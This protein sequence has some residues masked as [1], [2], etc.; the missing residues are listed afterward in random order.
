MIVRGCGVAVAGVLAV[1][2]VMNREPLSASPGGQPEH[3]PGRSC[4]ERSLQGRYATKTDGWLVLPVGLRTFA[5]AAVMSFDG[6][7]G[8]TN[9]AT[10]S[11]HGVIHK[12]VTY[13]SYTVNRDCTGQMTFPS[14]A[15]GMPLTFDIIIASGGWEIVFVGT[16]AP[17]SLT[18]AGKRIP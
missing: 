6:V 4:N 9:A 3:E 16:T 8:M 10:T 15:S 13:G 1:A 7:G 18:G 12:G 14:V 2:A 11:T 17:A 5:A